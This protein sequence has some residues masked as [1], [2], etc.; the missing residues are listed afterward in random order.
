MHHCWQSSL[1]ITAMACTRRFS[2]GFQRQQ[3][4]YVTTR[5]KTYT[6]M[7]FDARAATTP[8]PGEHL[9]SPEHAGLGLERFR[10]HHDEDS[11]LQELC[12]SREGEAA[13]SCIACRE[14]S[15]EIGRDHVAGFAIILWDLSCNGAEHRA[16]VAKY[17][18]SP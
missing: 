3:L 10:P 18:Y 9:T 12:R 14:A 16:S 11:P 6:D 2:L 4:T 13:S 17:P 5:K 8:K 15:M 1:R 7:S